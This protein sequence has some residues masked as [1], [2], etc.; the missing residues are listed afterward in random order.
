[1]GC[2]LNHA[3]EKSRGCC[4]S[5]NGSAFGSMASDYDVLKRWRC[6]LLMLVGEKEDELLALICDLSN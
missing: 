5:S 2:D 1:V 3:A 6:V 4:G